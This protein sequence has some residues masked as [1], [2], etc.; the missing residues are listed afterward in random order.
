MQPCY[1]LL[2][3]QILQTGADCPSAIILHSMWAG[4]RCW[5]W[6]RIK[7]RVAQIWAPSASF[8]LFIADIGPSFGL[9]V[10][11]I[12][13]TGADRPSAIILHSLWARARCWICATMK[14]NVAQIWAPSASF[15]LFIADIGPS[16]GLLVAQI[17]QTEVDRPSAIIPRGQMKVSGMGLIWASGIS[18]K[19]RNFAIR[20]NYWQKA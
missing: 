17:W 4:A 2:V 3:A 13:Q 8:G 15:G 7:I 11:Q 20:V 6:A 9:L 1:G 10:A 5:N 18:G 19:I 16:F 12:W 14:I